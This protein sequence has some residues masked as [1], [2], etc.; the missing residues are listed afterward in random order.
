MEV[1]EERE[2]DKKTTLVESNTAQTLKMAPR[3]SLN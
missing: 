3:H 1:S 2:D